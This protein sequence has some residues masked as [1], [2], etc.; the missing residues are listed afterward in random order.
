M[1]QRLGWEIFSEYGFTAR[2]GR[3]LENNKS[4]GWSYT[5]NKKQ[6]SVAWQFKIDDARGK[7]KYLYSK[8]LI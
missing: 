7:L 1:N 4:K 2:I 5:S 3:S 8:I 6:R